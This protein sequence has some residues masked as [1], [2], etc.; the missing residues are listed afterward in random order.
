MFVSGP[1]FVSNSVMFVAQCLSVLWWLSASSPVNF[2]FIWTLVE[3]LFLRW[4][5]STS[6]WQ[7][8]RCSLLLSRPSELSSQMCLS[9][10]SFTQ[11][12]FESGTLTVVFGCY[13]A[14]AMWNCCC[15]GTSSVYT[16][17]PC[18]KELLIVSIPVAQG[19]N[20]CKKPCLLML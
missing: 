12:D 19:I 1:V 17:Q 11:H 14:S 20:V 7:L 2:C 8:H 18:T 13:M 16:I 4:S 15:L 5:L 9:D 6:Q 3:C 10:C